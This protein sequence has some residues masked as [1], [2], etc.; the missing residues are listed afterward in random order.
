MTIA[1]HPVLLFG[2]ILIDRFPAQETPGGAPFNVT[3]HLQAFGCRPLL[4]TRIGED[5]AGA[6]LVR[7]LGGAGI[8][9]EGIQR[10]SLRPTG[11]VEVVL[12]GEGHRFD[13]LPDR[14]Y[15]HIDPD[16]SCAAARDLA[17]DLV[18]FGTL[19]QRAA[20]HLA[21]RRVLEVVTGQCFFDVNLRDPWVCTE[22]LDWSLE[23]ADHVKAN[24]GELA[25]IARLLDLREASAETQAEALIR[26]YRL[27]GMLVTCGA[28]GAWWMDDAARITR[29]A[30]GPAVQIRDT[31]GAG[32]AFSAVFM[33]GLLHGW[34]ISVAL[35]RAHAFAGAICGIRG[36]I[37]QDG[38]FYRPFLDRWFGEIDGH[39]DE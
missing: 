11:A 22:K 6:Y 29:T 31:V 35:Q 18:Y 28:Q 23:Q 32:D 33:L 19:A 38:D 3:W 12:S 25:C 37:P 14:A 21:L 15:D 4:V 9:T 10:D 2:E 36:A 1:R 27:R 17:P 34:A 13:I 16:R 26:R 7:A 30:A 8:E 20:S 39:A 5:A 24:D